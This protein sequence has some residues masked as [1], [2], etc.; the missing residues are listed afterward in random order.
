MDSNWTTTSKP[1]R[2]TIG[3]DFDESLHSFSRWKINRN[4]DARTTVMPCNNGSSCKILIAP[5]AMLKL[6][7]KSGDTYA[8]NDQNFRKI[9][10]YSISRRLRSTGSCSTWCGYGI[11]LLQTISGMSGR[12]FAKSPTSARILFFVV[13]MKKK[14]RDVDG[15]YWFNGSE[16]RC[17]V[18]IMLWGSRNVK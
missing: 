4:D 18:D 13:K 2:S 17:D 5:R 16:R 3:H 15:R 12:I 8:Y 7:S 10:K 14:Q 9:D 11:V 6:N 1:G